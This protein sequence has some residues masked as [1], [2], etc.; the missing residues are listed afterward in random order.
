[1]KGRYLFP[2]LITA[3]AVLLVASISLGT[4]VINPLRIPELLAAP[5]GASPD[6]TLLAIRLPRIAMSLL[7]GASL[8]VSGV[9]FQAILKNPLADPYLIGV[10]GGG[11]LGAT[12]AIILSLPYVL[13]VVCAFAGSSG[14][15]AAVYLMS[16]RMRFGTASLLL[17]GIALS[18]IFSSSV[19][20]LFAFA[21]PDKVHKAVMWLMGDMS[22]ARYEALPHLGIACALL[23]SAALAYSRHLDIISFGDA[24]AANLGVKASSVRALFWIAS[25]LAALSVSLCGMVGFVGLMVP[26]FMRL[27]GGPRHRILLPASFCCGAFFLMAADTLGRSVV[28]PFEIPVGVIT[29]FA[30]GIFFLAYLLVKREY[31]P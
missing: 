26:H 2:W 20:L 13:V 17:A 12:I 27:L 14:V 16:R 5:P 29:G 1:M 24:F 11:A 22:V 6:A 18:F 10:S 8:A 7:I 9:I 25:M 4:A 31:R 15:V 23:C 3:G 19:L 28:P 30:G 21:G